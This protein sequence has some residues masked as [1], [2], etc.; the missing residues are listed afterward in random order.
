MPAIVSPFAPSRA[1]LNHRRRPWRLS[2]NDAK[3]NMHLTA[4]GVVGITVS[5]LSLAFAVWISGDKIAAFRRRL[6]VKKYDKILAMAKRY[7]QNKAAFIADACFDFVVFV[8]LG[9]LLL[10]CLVM[11]AL[12]ESFATAIIQVALVLILAWKAIQAFL[13]V[14]YALIAIATAEDVARSVVNQSGGQQNDANET[15][16]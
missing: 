4:E 16:P 5:C 10:A 6:R 7:A 13:E 9:F 14:A 1:V 2:L 12:H 8:L 11:A 15:C 3:R